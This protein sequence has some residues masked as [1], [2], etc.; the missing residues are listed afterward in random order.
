MRKLLSATVLIFAVLIPAVVYYDKSVPIIFNGVLKAWTLKEK[1]FP[2]PG[3]EDWSPEARAFNNFVMLGFKP[4]KKPE[5]LTM[6][7]EIRSLA[8]LFPPPSSVNLTRSTIGNVPVLWLTPAD[9]QSPDVLIFFHGGG[10]VVGSADSESGAA[11]YLAKQLKIRVLSV[12]YRLAPENTIKDAIDD[13]LTV[14]KYLLET[15]GLRSDQI[16][17]HGCSAGGSMTLLTTLAIIKSGLPKPLAIA[18][19][20]VDTGF[21]YLS[22]T[23]PRSEWKSMK[24]EKKYYGVGVPEVSY[25]L[26]DLLKTNEENGATVKRYISDLSGLPPMNVQVAEYEWLLDGNLLLVE[27]LKKAGN[28][29]DLHVTPKM[30]HCPSITY[31]ALSEG[32]QLLDDLSTWIN[33]RLKSK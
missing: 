12:D 17:L 18:P 32:R 27:D 3:F 20:A 4:D 16:V 24:L 7:S 15:E 33:L 21:D 5:Y 25:Y 1:Y 23:K 19:W 26:E 2:T 31:S 8:L 9:V 28:E 29:V 10:F 30:W 6:R 14:Y 13:A 22:T 11:G